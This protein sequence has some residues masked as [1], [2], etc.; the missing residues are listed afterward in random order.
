MKKFV[1][2]LGFVFVQISLLAQIPTDSLVLHLPFNSN[3]MDVSG[4]GNELENN[5][6]ELTNDRFETP[7]SAALFSGDNNFIKIPDTDILDSTRFLTISCNINSNNLGGEHH[8]DFIP[9]ISKWFSYTHPDSCSYL[10][11]LDGNNI[12]F[13]VNDGVNRDT[14]D[15][16]IIFSVNEWVHI[17]CQFDN[18]TMKIYQNGVLSASKTSMISTIN[19]SYSNLEIG[20]WFKDYNSSYSSF[21]GEIDNVRIYRNALTEDEI[22]SLSNEGLRFETVY[23]TIQVYDTIYIAVIDTNLV[24]IY[25]TI[26]VTDTL[27]IDA[28]LT[29]I[30]PPNKTNTIKIYPNP[31][32]THIYINNGDYNS[33]NRYTV[34]VDNLLGQ[35]VFNQ[36][37]NQQEFYIDLS[38]WSGH[39]IYFV[40]IIDDKLNVIETKKIIIQ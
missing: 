40:Y 25:D 7:N 30:N 29:G 27:I 18:G 37:I 31:A 39:G 32:K 5:G 8:F 9:I 20:G 23:D 15:T 2:F 35:T 16:N 22:T 34:R 33:M 6:V 14:L 12:N 24:T 17:T 13:H 11:Y 28:V 3:F 38:D 36:N 26:S 19:N 10:I 4:Y 1:F 21:D